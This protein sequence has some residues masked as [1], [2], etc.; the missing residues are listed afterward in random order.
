MC[1][2][3]SEPFRRPADIHGALRGAAA[4]GAAHLPGLLTEPFRRRLQ[5]QI[6][7]L[8]FQPAPEVVGEVRQETETWAPTEGSG[9][10]PAV[11]SLR[12]AL[13]RAAR[14]SGIRGLRTWRPNDVAVQRY[15]PGSVGITSHRDGKRFRRLVAVVTTLGH[16]E[17]AIRRERRAEVV[18]RWTVGPGGLVLLRGPGL[19][20]ARDGRPFHEVSG[21]RAGGRYSIGFRMEV[22]R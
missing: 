6:E 17:F 18:A 21:P 10:P 20:G 16:A 9:S 7:S 11:E 4:E 5:R 12:R 8:P 15:G 1:G 3:A 14:E 22:R 13:V 19:A 2:M